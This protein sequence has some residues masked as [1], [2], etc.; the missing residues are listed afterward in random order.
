MRNQGLGLTN[1]CKEPPV[2]VWWLW[3][4]TQALKVVGLNPS[5]IYGM[6]IFSYWVCCK[7]CD[8]CLKTTEKRL[9]RGRG[10]PVK[11]P[12]VVAKKVL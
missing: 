2:L 11:K 10:W 1:L 8:V 6:D 5:T 4:E 3:D 9:K 7:N 12:S